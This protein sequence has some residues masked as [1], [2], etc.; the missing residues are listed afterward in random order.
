VRYKSVI[1]PLFIRCS[2]EYRPLLIRA[3]FH[4]AVV[5]PY[6]YYRESVAHTF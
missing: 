2:L 6:I 3:I 1:G 5:Y 4:T